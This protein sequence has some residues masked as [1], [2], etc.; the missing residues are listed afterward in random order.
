MTRKANPRRA[1]ARVLAAVALIAINV[2]AGAAQDVLA[3]GRARFEE[4][5]ALCHG[6]DARGHGPFAALLKVAP[7]DLT[8]LARAAGGGFPFSDAYRA[9]DGRDR[10]LAHGGADMPV[11]G[12][13]WLR[14][15]GDE[16]YV[17]GRVLEVLLYL[18]SLQQP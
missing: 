9:I 11:W 14:E 13:R 12:A 3:E 17:R 16:T 2:G 7:P 15:G 8:G 18:E 10:L 1:A 4:S 5:C 6:L